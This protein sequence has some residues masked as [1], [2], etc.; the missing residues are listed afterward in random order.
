[1][2]ESHV[3]EYATIRVVPRMEREEFLNV[4]VVLYCPKQKFLQ[5][6]ILIDE[7]KLAAFSS[8]LDI[9]QL[10]KNLCAFE[11][12]CNGD[13][14]GGP[15]ATLDIASRFRW[16]TATRSTIVQASKVHPGLCNDA[17]KTLNRLF[18]QLVV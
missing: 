18:N 10:E 6:M 15:I 14:E 3:F 16:L 9:E 7:D 8:K 2:Q 1:M 12:I 17:L 4:G 11:Q 5:A 13:K